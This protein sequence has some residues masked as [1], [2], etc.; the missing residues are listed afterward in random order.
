MNKLFSASIISLFLIALCSPVFATNKSKT[1]YLDLQSRHAFKP[2]GKLTI[3][4]DENG[5]WNYVASMEFDRFLRDKTVDLDKY[6]KN[7][8]ET[9]IKIVK[10][11]GGSSHLDFVSLSGTAPFSTKSKDRELTLKKLSKKDFDVINA[12]T[13][14]IELHFKDLKNST[15]ELRARIESLRVRETTFKFPPS[16]LY[17]DISKNSEFYEYTLNSQKKA[18]KDMRFDKPLFKILSQAGTGHPHGYTTGWV[19]NDEKFLYATVDFAADNT[20]DGNKD[21]AKLYANIKGNIKEFKLSVP[22][23]KWGKPLFDYTEDLP[24]QHKIYEFRIPLSEIG[25]KSVKDNKKLL[26]AF[27][28]YGTSDPGDYSPDIAYDSNLN[29]YLM[30][31]HYDDG[32]TDRDVYAQ[33]INNDGALNGSPITIADTAGLSAAARVAFDS[34]NNR[35]MVTWTDN[36]NHSTNYDIYAQIINGDGSLNGAAFPVNENIATTA[37]IVSDLAFDPENGRFLFA[38][39]LGT[40]DE[41]VKGRLF[42][43][44]G[45]ALTSTFD[46]STAAN[47]QREPVVKYNSIMNK[48]LVGWHD[49]RAGSGRDVWVRLIDSSGNPSGAEIQITNLTGEFQRNIDIASNEKDGG[50]LVAWDDT[51]NGQFDPEIWG[52]LID[53]TGALS[54]SN[55]QLADDADWELEYVTTSYNP[56][57]ENYLL[58]WSWVDRYG[59]ITAQVYWRSMSLNGS[60]FTDIEQVNPS[61]MYQI[62]S[63]VAPNSGNAT[64]LIAYETGDIATSHYDV[65]S[66]LKENLCSNPPTSPELVYPENEAVDMETAFTLAWKRASDPDSDNVNYDVYYCD[67]ADMTGCSGIEVID[68][69]N[70]SK[71]IS[72]GLSV[73]YVLLTLFMALG[74]VFRKK[75]PM[76][77]SILILMVTTFIFI[78]CSSSTIDEENDKDILTLDISGLNSATTYYWRVDAKDGN[79]RFTPSETRRFTTK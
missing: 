28:T 16:N 52:Q 76:R 58:S 75:R 3:Y 25:I 73:F 49:S 15:L 23:Q 26:L 74:I 21:Y 44:N 6:L 61:S 54:G 43:A 22:D 14:G 8:K 67:N 59:S 65:G 66:T 27:S 40:S 4:I 56:Y 31:Y 18:S 35:F 64:A 48:Y 78:A 34:I 41:D 10:S 51:R 20:F 17:R 62:N 63:I 47:A 11:T 50:F 24:Y 37:D 2:N 7:K 36:R 33:I 70:N 69:E 45:N 71:Y 38:W 79:G 39:N 77:I 46:I 42:D 5:S 32:S 57:C 29:R 9:K 1:T 55:F 72:S 60:T 19:R 13:N 30:V 53:V 12:D 68:P